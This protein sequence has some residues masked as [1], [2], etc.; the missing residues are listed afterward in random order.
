MFLSVDVPV[1]GRR[2]N[3]MRNNFTLPKGVGFPN[4]MSDGLSETWADSQT[5]AYGVFN[6]FCRYCDQLHAVELTAA[7]CH[8]GL[9]NHDSLAASEHQHADMAER[10]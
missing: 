1:L 9:G 2:L 7:R 8:A 5:K 10:W 3:E 6:P 4:I